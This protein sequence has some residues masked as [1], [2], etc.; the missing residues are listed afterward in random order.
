[1]NYNLLEPAVGSYEKL[2]HDKIS[3]AGTDAAT[4]N[5]T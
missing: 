1:M 5:E 4:Y 2:N 3:L